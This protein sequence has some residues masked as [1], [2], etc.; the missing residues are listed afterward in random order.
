MVSVP[1]P[2][3]KNALFWAGGGVPKS[4]AFLL[5]LLLCEPLY[6]FCVLFG[7][8]LG[9]RSFGRGYFYALLNPR[10]LKHRR[11]PCWLGWGSPSGRAGDPGSAWV[12]PMRRSSSSSPGSR[13]SWCV[14]SVVVVDG[15]LSRGRQVRVI[16]VSSSLGR[17]GYAQPSSILNLRS[18]ERSFFSNQD[19]FLGSGDPMYSQE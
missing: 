14:L 18:Q 9:R 15:V 1:S 8:V 10:E 17:R 16:V 6:C 4:E 13:C 12:C 5:S 7:L 11:H 19:G 2:L 3:L